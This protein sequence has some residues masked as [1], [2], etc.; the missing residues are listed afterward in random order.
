MT[1]K[2]KQVMEEEIQNLEN[3]WSNKDIRQSII[4]ILETA[5]VEIVDEDMRERMK[6]NVHDL[7]EQ[8]EFIRVKYAINFIESRIQS[9]LNSMKE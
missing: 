7:G 8:G 2:T 4:R 3:E 9:I 1:T 5:M 6:Y